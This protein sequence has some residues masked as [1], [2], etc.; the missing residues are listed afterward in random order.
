MNMGQKFGEWGSPRFW[1]GGAG[2]PQSRLGRGLSP[3]QVAV[4]SWSMQPFGHNRYGPKIGGLCPFGG[5]GAGS[6]SDAICPGLSPTCMPSFVLIHST[7]WPQCTNVTD[8]G[9]IA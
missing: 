1:R 6:P 9:P 3:Y 5:G 4:A 7:V 2:S 8:K